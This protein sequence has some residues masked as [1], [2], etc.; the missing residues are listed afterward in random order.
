[1]LHTACLFPDPTL[2]DKSPHVSLRYATATHACLLLMVE[3][4]KSYLRGGRGKFPRCPEQSS[5]SAC[6]GVRRAL[7]TDTG[8][9]RELPRSA[10]FH[11]SRTIQQNLIQRASAPGHLNGPG[12]IPLATSQASIAC[13]RTDPLSQCKSLADNRVVR[14]AIACVT[15][16]PSGSS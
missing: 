8:E 3:L 9:N 10:R 1:M 14:P 13:L 5:H 7:N 4:L 15:R 11:E 2:P 6:S 16:V 12:T